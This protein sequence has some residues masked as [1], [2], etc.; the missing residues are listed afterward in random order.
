MNVRLLLAMI[1]LG[2]ATSHAAVPATTQAVNDPTPVAAVWHEVGYPPP[3]VTEMHRLVVGVW[4]DGTVVTSADPARGGRP[5][6]VRKVDSKQ[7][8]HL[9]AGLIAIGFFDDESLKNEPARPPDAGYTAVA[10]V[11]GDKHQRVA[12]W[13]PPTTQPAEGDHYAAQFLKARKLIEQLAEG[14]GEP[15][16]K[17]DER[18]FRLGR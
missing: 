13:R 1:L 12:L 18:V 4:S 15:I 9:V 17:I 3:G 16:D 8:D 2:S 10:A 7:V 11:A 14:K 5:Y 6:T